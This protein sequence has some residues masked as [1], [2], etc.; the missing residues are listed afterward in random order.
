MRVVGVL[1]AVAVR[2]YRELLA[3]P[4]VRRV[5]SWGLIA[6]MPM[7]MSALALV[8]LMRGAGYSYAVAG[9]ASALNTAAAG[10]GA[11]VGG[12]LVDR[13]RASRVLVTYGAL[14]GGALAWLFLAARGGA[15]VGV[16]LVLAAVAGA[17]TPPVGPTVRSLWPQLVP[18][19][20]Q[21][22]TAFALEATAQELI[23]VTGPLV[24]AVLTALVSSGFGV[25]GA[26]VAG[27]LGAVGFAS[28]AAI[29]DRRPDPEHPDGARHLLAALGPRGVRRVLAF[30]AGLGLA[31]GAVEVAIPAFAE[32]HGGRSLAGIALA[33]W[34]AGSLV[35]GLLAASTPPAD[36][37]RRLRV[38]SALFAAALALP[39][40]AGSV[41][42]LAAVMFLAGLPIAPS[43]AITYNLIE[44]AAVRGTEAEVFGWISTAVTAG[45]AVGT[46]AGGSLIVHVGVHASILLGMGGALIAAA[47]ALTRPDPA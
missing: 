19:A 32:H 40:F 9:V 20:E 35:G 28:T 23:F 1:E 5:V 11:P 38:V 31:F 36:P 26:G 7:G 29:R 2:R 47:V 46:A 39:L 12:R 44:A 42:A 10:I 27:A 17:A 43:F 16:L 21:R 8:L 37:H 45:I 6:R 13:N 3:A 33:A 4:D 24:V 18:S 41:P 14:Y 22:V 15:P 25:V 30:S 34:S